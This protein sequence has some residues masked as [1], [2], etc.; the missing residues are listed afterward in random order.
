MTHLHIYNIDILIH[1]SIWILFLSLMI[2]YLILMA[3]VSDQM[4]ILSI[5][6][7]LL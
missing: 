3:C 7:G 6:I 1:A 4:D 5:I 2:I